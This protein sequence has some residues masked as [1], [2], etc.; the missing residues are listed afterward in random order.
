M[1]E[2][3]PFNIIVDDYL[4]S[5]CQWCGYIFVDR[6]ERAIAITRSGP[7]YFCKA[8]PEHPDQSCY[9]RYRRRHP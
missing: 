5:H 7:K 3:Q 6:E 1:G 8:H 4:P 9:L 2:V